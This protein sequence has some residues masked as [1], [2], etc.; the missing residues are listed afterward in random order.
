MFPVPFS[1]A[2]RV[3]IMIDWHFP[4]TLA[5]FNQGSLK[6]HYKITNCEAITTVRSQPS[7]L[8]ISNSRSTNLAA[9]VSNLV[10][11]SEAQGTFACFA[12]NTLHFLDIKEAVVS[13]FK[14]K[15]LYVQSYNK[16]AQKCS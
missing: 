2:G 9:D 5:L 14:L 4:S 10:C 8:V 3:L 11:V 1:R 12:K 16:T 15:M 7:S 13:C 6:F